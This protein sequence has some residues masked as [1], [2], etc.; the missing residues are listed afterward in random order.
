MALVAAWFTREEFFSFIHRDA[1]ALL[2]SALVLLALITYKYL[3]L[4]RD[5]RGYV[6]GSHESV[7]THRAQYLF[8]RYPRMARLRPRST[9]RRERRDWLRQQRLRARQQREEKRRERKAS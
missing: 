3:R 2:V 1:P 6:H 8:S 5:A 7:D 9:R 4:R